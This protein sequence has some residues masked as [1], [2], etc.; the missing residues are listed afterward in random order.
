[1][2]FDVNIRSICEVED[3][4]LV[5]CLLE[6]YNGRAPIWSDHIPIQVGSSMGVMTPVSGD[7]NDLFL[8]DVG[9]GSNYS[10]KVGIVVDGNKTNV[11]S[12]EKNVNSEDHYNSECAKV[13]RSKRRKRTTGYFVS[14]NKMNE[15]IEG[16]D[17]VVGTM[18]TNGVEG[19][20]DR[21]V[22]EGIE[23][24]RTPPPQKAKKSNIARREE[25][26]LGIPTVYTMAE[27]LKSHANAVEYFKLHDVLH[28]HNGKGCSGHAMKSKGRGGP[29][30]KVPCI[31]TLRVCKSKNEPVWYRFVLFNN[32]LLVA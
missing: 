27:E 26:L 32:S 31:G 14:G 2:S 11:C 16:M 24:E 12:S 19:T 7:H 21:E 18:S 23:I 15:E 4:E 29:A 28:D 10:R 3:S 8:N 22:I 9:E 5:T 1:M 30:Q 17:D 6:L 13:S 25:K 20:S